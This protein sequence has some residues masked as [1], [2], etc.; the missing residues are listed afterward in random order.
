[1]KKRVFDFLFLAVLAVIIFGGNVG[2]T[3]AAASNVSDYESKSLKVKA[4]LLSDES[5]ASKTN[6]YVD[7]KKYILAP[8]KSNYSGVL[9]L[10]YD[11]LGKGNADVWIL[12]SCEIVNGQVQGMGYNL[13][14]CYGG[15]KKT[16][17]GGILIKSG[18]KYWLY[19]Q[20][21]SKKILSINVRGTLY[22][23]S[24]NRTLSEGT[25]QWTIASGISPAGGVS[26]IFYR[27][28]PSET[29]YMSVLLNSYGDGKAKGKV[30]L[31]NRNK[32]KIS[33]TVEYESGLSGTDGKVYF[34]VNKGNTYYVRVRNVAD[35]SKWAYKYGVKYNVNSAK[36][37]LIGT[38]LVAKNLGRKD[39]ATKTLLCADGDTSTDWYKFKVTEKRKTQIKIET[40]RIKSGNITISFYKG[41]KKIGASKLISAKS[42][43]KV[44]TVESD[45]TTGKAT[46]GTYYVK[47]VK[48]KNSSGLYSIRYVQ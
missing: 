6:Y 5:K 24:T 29:G 19:V 4:I 25:S 21:T 27:I 12:E 46:A 42:N 11:A 41:S 7:S 22:L 2:N 32:E 39:E 13:G 48:S 34:G 9:W 30:I 37:R 8:I 33:D 23:T 38:R 35:S 47:I 1:M 16:S 36:D 20:N 45:S 44:F 43:G 31:Y 15:T 40:S 26:D 14:K 10:D 17:D 3:K 18:K 28:C